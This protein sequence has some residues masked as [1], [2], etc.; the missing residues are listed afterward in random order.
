MVK[1]G[2]VTDELS[3]LALRRLLQQDDLKVEKLKGVV[4]AFEKDEDLPGCVFLVCL[5]ER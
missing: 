4:M 2:Q 1:N 3:L 5:R